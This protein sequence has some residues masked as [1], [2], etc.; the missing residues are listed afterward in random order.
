MADSE[1]LFG[2][3][4]TIEPDNGQFEEATEEETVNESASEPEQ[5]EPTEGASSEATQP[6][7]PLI[8]GK[9]KSQDDLVKAYTNL[10]KY[11]TRLSQQ[12]PAPKV[13]QPKEDNEEARL[14]A[15]YEA[16]VQ[17]NPA[18]ANAVLAQYIASKQI[19]QYKKEFESQLQPLRE[20]R[21][22]QETF[23]TLKEQYPDISQYTKGMESEINEMAESD[24]DSLSD[25]RLYEIA[26]FRAKT[27]AIEEQMKTAFDNGQKKAVETLQQKKKVVN[28]TS[29]AN[30]DEGDNLPPG[31]HITNERDGIFL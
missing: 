22:L 8:L 16:N 12:K 4:E 31:I 29:K 26:Y 17:T 28:E 27:K 23:K 10:E 5:A 2:V 19:E 13:E 9:F 3:A 1:N 11:A 15:W 20:E 7:E 24:P 6:T 25:P 18:Q 21:K 14:M 30:I